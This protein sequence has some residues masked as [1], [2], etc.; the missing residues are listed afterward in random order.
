MPAR[1]FPFPSPRSL[2]VGSFGDAQILSSATPQSLAGEC[3]IAE[4]RLDL[5]HREF[6]A[7]GR[8]LWRH[9]ADFPLLFTARCQAEGSPVDLS[10]QERRTMLEAALPDASL[11]DIEAANV[12]EMA[13]VIS[14]MAELEIPW[15]ASYHD[16]ENMPEAAILEARARI[17]R[18]AGAA[19]FKCAARLGTA[20]DLAALARFQSSHQGIPLSTMGMGPLAP[21]S[22]L[23]CAQLGSVLNY[24]YIGTVET[25]P[26]QWSA[27]RLREN[28]LTLRPLS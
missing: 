3:D 12:A 15:V 20:D 19:A 18:E 11:V 8:G 26:G 28:I 27:K 2:V 22:R 10:E 7:T 5:V 16:F 6:A 25:A 4:I 21:V 14:R 24:G 9:L 13:A 23:L 17:A 1:S